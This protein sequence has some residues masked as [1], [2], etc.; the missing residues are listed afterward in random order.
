[1]VFWLKGEFIHW[2]GTEYEGGGGDMWRG[3]GS[4]WEGV[5]YMVGRVNVMC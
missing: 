4:V 3:K 5:G 1:M 2:R